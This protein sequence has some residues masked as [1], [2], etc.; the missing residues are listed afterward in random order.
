MC[1]SRLPDGEYPA[2]FCL[3]IRHNSRK[4]PA[5]WPGHIEE[6]TSVEAFWLYLYDD[7]TVA[8]VHRFAQERLVSNNGLYTIMKDLLI[9][10]YRIS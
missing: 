6:G 9:N 1:G 3:L 8:L 5:D 2:P 10:Y 4:T 7:S